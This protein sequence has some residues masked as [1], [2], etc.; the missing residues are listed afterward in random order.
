MN[1]LEEMIE[2]AWTL[3]AEGFDERTFNG[4]WRS[5]EGEER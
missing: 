3:K 4:F 5:L 2:T 1:W